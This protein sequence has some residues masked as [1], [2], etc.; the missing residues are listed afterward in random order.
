MTQTGSH[1]MVAY[2]AAVVA[3]VYGAGEGENWTGP[4][5]DVDA[6]PLDSI[7]GAGLRYFGAAGAEAG[8]ASDTVHISEIAAA[9]AAPP[10]DELGALL[11]Y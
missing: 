10:G 4:A 6:V 3:A 2:I 9:L 8:V 1:Q 7:V 11:G 5:F